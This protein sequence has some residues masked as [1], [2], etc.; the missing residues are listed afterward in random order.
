MH[1]YGG[2]AFIVSDGVVYFSNF[3]DQRLY[4]QRPGDEPEPITPETAVRY[5]D[6]V[7]DSKRAR[8]ICIREDHRGEG[9]QSPRS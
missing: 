8:I 3:E 1:E 4:R 6:G 2:G 9:R 5:A 7:M